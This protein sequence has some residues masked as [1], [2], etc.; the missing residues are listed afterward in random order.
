M[1]YNN[2]DLTAGSEDMKNIED[3]L[4]RGVTIYYIPQN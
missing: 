3:L 1:Q 2:L 4:E